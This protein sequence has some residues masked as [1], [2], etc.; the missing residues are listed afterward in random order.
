MEDYINEVLKNKLS[1]SS[2]DSEI[3]PITES[4]K[5]DEYDIPS[6]NIIGGNNNKP[7]GGFPPLIICDKKEIEKEEKSKV[8]NFQVNKSAVSMR[9]IM[10]ERKTQ[11]N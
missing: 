8:K 2:V 11:K 3:Y 9:D 5:T 10:N 7:T 4:Q 1:E 6:V